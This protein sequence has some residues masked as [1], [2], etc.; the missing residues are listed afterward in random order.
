MFWALL[1]QFA[2]FITV[3]ALWARW[4]TLALPAVVVPLFYLGLRY[5]W[6]GDGVGDGWQLVALAVTLAGVAVAAATVFLTRRVRP[7]N[8]L[9]VRGGVPFARRGR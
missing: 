8:D 3:A 6:W 1:A 2:L 4:S 7:S 5:G 9:P